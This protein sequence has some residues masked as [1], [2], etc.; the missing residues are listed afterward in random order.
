MSRNSILPS[1]SASRQP[2]SARIVSGFSQMPPIIISRPASIRL[3]MAISPSR[4]NSSTDPISRRYM[5]TGSSVRPIS[6]SSRLPRAS[7]IAVLGLGGG[8][9]LGLLAFD[10][11]DAEL[12]QHRHRVLDLL[13]GHLIRGQGGVQ[14]V[15]GDV[16]PLP[17]AGQHL[18]DRGGEEIEQWCFGCLLAGFRRFSRIRR[19]TRHSTIPRQV[20]TRPAAARRYT[21]IQTGLP[22]ISLHGGL[23]DQIELSLPPFC[24]NARSLAARKCSQLAADRS[25]IR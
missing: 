20:S 10:D 19:F 9:L 15:I 8:R 21:T 4:D 5:R 12:G 23:L 25:S 7:A 11:V 14:L 6:S 17:A 22:T 3:A 2:T 13:R 18:L 24:C 1:T 16:S